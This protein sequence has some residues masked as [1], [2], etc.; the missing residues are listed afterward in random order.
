MDNLF[1]YDIMNIYEYF[2][3]NILNEIP[4]NCPMK[5]FNPVPGFHLDCRR[6]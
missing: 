5:L 2:F 3:M 1:H 4:S 6:R